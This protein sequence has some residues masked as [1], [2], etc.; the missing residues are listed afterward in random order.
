MI[1]KRGLTSNKTDT[2]YYIKESDNIML[3]FELF[4]KDYKNSFGASLGQFLDSV[5]EKI[6]ILGLGKVT[7]DAEQ[8]DP[9]NN[10]EKIF[11]TNAK[12]LPDFIYCYYNI[13]HNYVFPIMDGDPIYYNYPTR[14]M[15]LRNSP[16]LL[17]IALAVKEGLLYAEERHIIDKDKMDL[18]NMEFFIDSITQKHILPNSIFNQK[19]SA[20]LMEDTMFSSSLLDRM[21]TQEKHR[22]NTCLSSKDSRPKDNTMRIM[23]HIREICWEVRN[24]PTIESFSNNLGKYCPKMNIESKCNRDSIMALKESLEEDLKISLCY[25]TYMNIA[26]FI[27]NYHEGLKLLNKLDD[28]ETNTDVVVKRI[29]GNENI[30]IQTQEEEQDKDEIL[31]EKQVVREMYD[32]IYEF[33]NFM[34]QVSKERQNISEDLSLN[35]NKAREFMRKHPSVKNMIQEMVSP[36]YKAN[37]E[38]VPF[39]LTSYQQF[40]KQKKTQQ[41][42]LEEQRRIQYEQDPPRPWY[43]I[44]T[45]QKETYAKNTTKI[46][47]IGS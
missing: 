25:P 46:G 9:D 41:E 33:S 20:P 26:V 12:E 13:L 4:Q 24:S 44:R 10:S 34:I 30:D 22:M 16:R 43:H 5:L 15:R 32:Y 38:K 7:K 45:T 27:A 31:K 23:E 37:Q 2:L 8:I 6:K 3:W 36:S 19:G 35:C 29:V 1:E 28:Y 14:M 18:K 11:S 42:Q 39:S 47:C 17:A 21:L 40:E